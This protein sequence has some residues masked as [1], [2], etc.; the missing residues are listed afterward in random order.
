M[1]VP[2]KPTVTLVDLLRVITFNDQQPATVS[3]RRLEHSLK[4]WFRKAAMDSTHSCSKLGHQW[5]IKEV[6]GNPRFLRVAG[7]TFFI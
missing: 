6:K 4:A 2:R 5:I 7:C 3:P 1:F